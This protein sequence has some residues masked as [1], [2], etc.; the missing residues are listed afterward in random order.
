MLC[1]MCDFSHCLV[2]PEVQDA[3]K[4][5]AARNQ[6][7]IIVNYDKYSARELTWLREDWQDYTYKVE[8]SPI[9]ETI[10]IHRGV[11]RKPTYM[12]ISWDNTK[13]PIDKTFYPK[14]PKQTRN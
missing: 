10:C 14:S 3:M 9:H 12:I 1:E 5:A 2:Y 4:S 6:K 7:S 11:I 13:D 8:L